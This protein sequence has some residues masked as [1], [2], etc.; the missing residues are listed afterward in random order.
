M[1]ESLGAAKAASDEATGKTRIF[2]WKYTDDDGNDQELTLTIP[3]KYKRFKFSRKLATGDV[4]GALETVFKNQKDAVAQIEEIEMDDDEFE[5][6][7]ER[8]GEALGGTSVK[9]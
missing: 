3:R 6:F 5:L 4:M 9:N 7:M 8:L 1:A 2:V